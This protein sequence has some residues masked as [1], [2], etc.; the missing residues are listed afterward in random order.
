M[1]G[2]QH[3]N[4]AAAAGRNGRTSKGKQRISDSKV[5]GEG[6]S[7]REWGRRGKPGTGIMKGSRVGFKGR[8]IYGVRRR[9]STQVPEGE[10]KERKTGGSQETGGRGGKLS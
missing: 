2:R 9:E 1:A 8:T 6:K 3:L 4:D 7:R 10:L 5:W